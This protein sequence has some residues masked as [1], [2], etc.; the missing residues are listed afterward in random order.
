[1]TT[2]ELRKS[3]MLEPKN[4]YATLT[5]QQREVMERLL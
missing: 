2:E 5:A 4:G 3:L 1:M